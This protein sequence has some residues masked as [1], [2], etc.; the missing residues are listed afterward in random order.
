MKRLL[1][2][3][4]L[5]AGLGLGAACRAGGA[6]RG[7]AAAPGDPALRRRGAA[8]SAA[9]GSVAGRAP[10]ATVVLLA[11]PLEADGSLPG[12]VAPAGGAGIPRIELGVREGRIEPRISAAAMRSE[13]S[14]V[15]KDD[16]FA[17]VS[18]YFGLTESAF[19]HKFVLA[20]DRFSFRLSRPGLMVFENENRPSDRSYLYVAP[21]A[22]VTVAGEEG[23]YEI[24][25]I[26]A[27]R[28]RF[29]A[30]NEARGVVDAA[31]V[32]QRGKTSTLDFVFPGR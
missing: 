4:A 9:V 22:A 11:D 3:A 10:A 31:A 30:W 5:A 14:L 23:R 12:A 25:G 19:R 18:A 6:R 26:G 24:G 1:F 8:G 27:G 20:G 32:V 28:H 17:D 21:T 7:A 2:S 13:L 16:V 15:S 29:T